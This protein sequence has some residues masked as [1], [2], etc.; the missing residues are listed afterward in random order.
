MGILVIIRGKRTIISGGHYQ[1]SCRLERC[2]FSG[3]RKVQSALGVRQLESQSSAVKK[4]MNSA[5]HQCTG[6]VRDDMVLV[7]LQSALELDSY[8]WVRTL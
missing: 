4:K 8:K 6:S 2:H 3:H 1:E 7:A 5:V